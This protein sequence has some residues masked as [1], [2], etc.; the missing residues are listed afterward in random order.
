MPAVSATHGWIDLFDA[1]DQLKAAGYLTEY[2]GPNSLSCGSL[3]VRTSPNSPP[4]RMNVDFGKVSPR[5]VQ[6]L[7]KKLQSSS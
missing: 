4:S 7:I 2:A 6:R 3:Y 1:I 5:T